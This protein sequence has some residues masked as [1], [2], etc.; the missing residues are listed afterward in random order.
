MSPR[1]LLRQ[2]AREMRGAGGRIAFF[3]LSLAVGVASVVGVA[4]L[5]AGI[6]GALRREAR[7]LLAGDLKIESRRPLPPEVDAA[8]AA[9]AGAARA[10]VVE[11]VTVAAA[12]PA[13]DGT[14]G[15]SALVELKAVAGP[16]P[17][18]GALGLDPALP[19][20]ELLA[21]DGAVAAPDLLS[22]LGIPAGGEILV[23]GLRLPIR[24]TVTSEPDRIAG[25][26]SV[27]PRLF[28][29]RDTLARAGLLG[30]GSRAEYRALVRLRP[31]ADAAEVRAVAERLGAEIGSPQLRIET[32]LE[33]Q[34][35]LRRGLERAERFL[36]LVALLSLLVGGV[37]V[38][39]TVSAWLAA[40]L[41]AIAVLKCLGVRPREVLALYVGQTALLAA[42]GSAAGALA[43]VAFAAVA[44]RFAPAALPA[45]AFQLWQPGA[46]ARGAA[47]GIGVALLFALPPLVGLLRVPAARVLRRDAEPP[48]PS[49]WLAAALALALALGVGATASAQARSLA[50]GFAFTGALALLAALLWA[51]ARGLAALSRRAPR[52]GLGVAWRYG[53]AALGRPGAATLGAVVS[54]GL[55]VMVVLALSLVQ[56]QLSRQLLAEIPAG[57]PN[58]FLVDIQTDQ[59]PQLE[60]RLGELGAQA[61]DSV[62]VVMARL[63]AIDGVAAAELAER[64][65]QERG[66]RRWALTREQR[67]TYLERLPDDNT[68][69]AG[70][71]WSDPERAEVSVEEEFARDLGLALGSRLAFDVQGVP[72][73]LV[74][75]SLRRVRWESFG[76]NFFLVVEPGVLDG[77]PQQRLAT[78]RFPAG[79]EQ[80]AQD[81][82]ARDFPNVTLLQVRELLEKV[83]A[84]MRRIGLGVRFLGGFTVVAGIAI[85]AGAIG[86]ASARRGREVALL[87]ALGMGRRQVVAA[88]ALEY[89]LVGLVAGAIGTAAALLLSWAVLT[90]GME[91]RWALDPLP[92]AVALAGTVLLAA[93]AGLGA[94]LGALARRPVEALRHE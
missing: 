19:L 65:G 36:G 6:D 69:V 49:R 66:E 67:L 50:L 48:P 1:F 25:A 32:Y 56:R 53:L 11:L 15:R 22:R 18:Y 61:I 79:G 87:K 86:A 24:A 80:R 27:G 39:Q 57:A 43:G 10:D 46:L 13:A 62:P 35:S 70:A 85:L 29:S 3:T 33:A 94:S 8:L 75:T 54:L 4:S 16:Y 30:R 88:L 89:G 81:A 74:V 55:G 60:R 77:A 42:A 52:R 73:E 2:L 34:P 47:L 83:A 37:G 17:L 31:G 9:L 58:A 64:T 78:A 82:L 21:G 40:R 5:S 90:H 72:V 14:P 23:G 41:D 91:V 44:I 76:I 59:W 28:V 20:G 7:Q 45:G 12:P 71:L 68:L 92:V 93:A 38:A 63:A 84:V 51:A 26:F